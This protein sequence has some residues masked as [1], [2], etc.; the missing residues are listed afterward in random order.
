MPKMKYLRYI[1]IALMLQ[2]AIN[3]YACAGPSYHPSQTAEWCQMYQPGP[4]EVP[5]DE[6]F[7]RVNIELWKEDTYCEYPDSMVAELVYKYPLSKVEKL[8]KA[9][10]SNDT[11]GCGEI[12]EYVLDLVKSRYKSYSML[13]FLCVAKRCEETRF[14]IYDDEWYYPV[15]GDEYMSELENVVA[16]CRQEISEG[17]SVPLY[18]WLLQEMRALMSLGRYEECIARWN[19]LRK[20]IRNNAFMKQIELIVAQ[21]LEHEGR[22]ADALVLYAKYNEEDK[23]FSL[24]EGDRID[25]IEYLYGINPNSPYFASKLYVE[26]TDLS[27]GDNP[28]EPGTGQTLRDSERL[29]ELSKRVIKEHRTE[30]MGPW[31]YTAATC[32]GFL[33]RYSEAKEFIRQGCQKSKREYYPYL[34]MLHMYID[35]QQSGYTRDYEQRLLSDLQCVDNELSGNMTTEVKTRL[36]ESSYYGYHESISN[37]YW[38]DA[39]RKILIKY[40]VPKAMSANKPVKALQLLA[41]ADYRAFNIAGLEHFRQNY[42]SRI[43]AIDYATLAFECADTMSLSSLEQFVAELDNPKDVMS[44]FLLSRGYTNADYWNELLG[45][46]YLRACEYDKAVACLEKVSSEFQYTTNVWSSG[47]YMKRNPF[48]YDFKSRD[49]YIDDRLDYKLRFASEMAELTRIYKTASDPNRRA[50]AMIRCAVGM[51][52]SVGFC[53]ALTRYE[54]FVMFYPE[55]Y[56]GVEEMI[57]KSEKLI[58]QAFKL[59]TN[60]EIEA[61]YRYEFFQYQ[62]IVDNLIHT[63]RGRAVINNCDIWRDYAKNRYKDYLEAMY[64][65]Y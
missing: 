14:K 18:R 52:N 30:N 54:D 46:R 8:L 39:M 37:Y 53:W 41:Y 45:T 56:P 20:D 34:R 3:N 62:Y 27:Q 12:N 43:N 61:E 60:K 38:N 42:Y 32:C 17:G 48:N 1:V 25:R 64:N 47:N 40:V 16:T 36:C 49:S 50:A 24:I 33:S 2:C 58:E 51:R 21:A 31:Y 55:E 6:Q 65:N 9:L 11:S 4:V 35:A 10:E 29:L 23:L 15:P 26:L 28:Y 57:E 13:E 5:I 44:R 19:E 7:S 22:I 59:F 63:S